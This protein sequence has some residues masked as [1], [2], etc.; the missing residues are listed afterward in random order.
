MSRKAQ[1]QSKADRQEA[2]RRVAERSTPRTPVIYETVSQH[3]EEEMARPAVSLWWSGIAAGLSIS[4]SLL[5]EALLRLR[6]P[7]APWRPLFTSLG[8]PVGFLIVVLGRQQLFTENTITA[9]LP[10][11]S[12]FSKRNLYRLGRLWGI[13]FLANMIGT[14]I[15]AA[16]IAFTPAVTGSALDAMLQVSREAVEHGW[17][18]MFFLAI[19][20]GFLIAAMVWLLPSAGESVQFHVV[21][22]MTYLI[23]LGGFAHI[24]A[25]SV[26]AFLLLWRGELGLGAVLGGFTLPVLF[27]NIIGGTV[28]F[29]LISYAQVMREIE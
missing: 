13:V 5:A 16:F 28:L 29:A 22:L 24:V 15:A 6:I 3:G 7:D 8:Y 27:G 2:A 9:V 18:E 23:G 20:A 26:E 21:G 4:F 10:A 25:G 19:P 17:L 12:H 14:L 11:M 1:Q